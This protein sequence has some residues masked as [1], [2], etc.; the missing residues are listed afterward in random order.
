LSQPELKNSEIMGNEDLIQRV[1]GAAIAV[2]REL[3]PGYLE[4]VYEEALAVEFERLSIAFERQKIIGIMFRGRKAGEHRL[5]F[6]VE[7]CVVIELKAVQELV[8]VF[9]A[10][11]RSY[12]K[13]ARLSDAL[14]LNSASMPLTIKRV[15]P[16][17]IA[18][19]KSARLE[20]VSF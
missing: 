11:V 7:G 14:L 8:P 13:A 2:H 20:E 3:G 19:F 18:R 5:D 15:G 9:F 10:V 17:D 16:E 12:L 6:L 1:I 4:A